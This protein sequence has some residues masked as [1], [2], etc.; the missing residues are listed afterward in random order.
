MELTTYRRVLPGEYDPLAHFYPRV[1][2][3]Q[4]HPL[5][6]FFLSL[7]NARIAERY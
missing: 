3:A 6:R 7:G 1:P 4:L 2:N 5:V